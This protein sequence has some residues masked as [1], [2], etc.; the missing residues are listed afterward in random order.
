MINQGCQSYSLSDTLL[1]VL[2]MADCSGWFNTVSFPTEIYY[3]ELATVILTTIISK[4]DK[5]RRCLLYGII[6]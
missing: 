3:I 6:V 4:S 1:T 2:L 5:K